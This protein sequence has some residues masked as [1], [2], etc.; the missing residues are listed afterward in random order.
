MPFKSEAQRGWMYANEPEMAKR[1][2]KH[3]PKGKKLPG[4]V[5]KSLFEKLSENSFWNRWI[6]PIISGASWASLGSLAGGAWPAL[7]RLTPVAGGVAAIE[8][9]RTAFNPE[10]ARETETSTIGKNPVRGIWNAINP[11]FGGRAMG[12]M[13]RMPFERPET[14]KTHEAVTP[15]S[16]PQ[17]QRVA[18]QMRRQRARAEAMQKGTIPVASPPVIAGSRVDVRPPVTLGQKKGSYVEK[19]WTMA[20]VFDFVKEAKKKMP[21]FT[22]Q[23]RPAKVKQVYKALKR[24]HP[25]MP[26][27]MK[28]RIAS[29]K[30]SSDPSERKSGPP[31]SGPLSKKKAMAMPAQMQ[32]SSPPTPQQGTSAMPPSTGAASAGAGAASQGPMSGN[33]FSTLANPQLKGFFVGQKLKKLDQQVAAAPADGEGG[34]EESKSAQIHLGTPFTDGFLRACLDAGL[35]EESTANVLEK[36]AELQGEQGARCRDLLDRI[37]QAK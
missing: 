14:G 22:E 10:L 17:E 16:I 23:D 27:G 20:T 15:Q 30:G 11:Q 12:A 33:P 25:G 5:K 2:E 29:R 18:Q 7:S 36:G 6:N 4:H 1:W 34:G 21:H 24:E 26:A 8:A 37:L 3:T 13:A 32:L 35:N 9:G 28:A 31:Y 19:G